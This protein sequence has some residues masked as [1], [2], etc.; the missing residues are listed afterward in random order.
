MNLKFEEMKYERPD[1]EDIRKRI[2]DF[3]DEF[4]SADN[5]QKQIDIIYD[6]AQLNREFD[7]NLNLV[8]VRHSIDTR[9]EFYD[10]EN[11]YWDEN[12]PLVL[13]TSNLMYKAI[14]NSKFKDELIEEFG[15]HYFDLM[16]CDLVLDERATPYLQK[17]NALSS[18]YSK[19][20]ANSKIEFRGKTYTL[21]Q[22]APHLQNTDRAYRKEAYEKRWGF[23]EDNQKKIDQ[24]YDDMVKERTAMAKALGFNSY[25]EL[26]YKL[27]KRTDYKASDVAEYREKVRKFVSPLAKKLR[28]EQSSRIGID[29]FKFYDESLEYTDGNPNPLGEEKFI[30]ENGQKMYRNLSKETGEFFDF[31]VEN[32]LLDLTAKP[33]KQGGGY[34]T[35]FD[36][37]K[38]PFIFANFNGT[39]GDIEVITHEAGHAFQNYMSQHHKL[40]EYVWPTMESAEIHSM[41]M[42]FLTWKYMELFVGKNMAEKY[43][44]SH[45]KNAIIFIP[46]GVLIDHFQ[47]V[48]YDNPELS[49]DERRAEF[50]KLEKMYR[51]EVD[52]DNEF[53]DKGSYWYTQGHVFGSP[54]YYI[55]YTLAQVCAFQFLLKNLEDSKEALRDYFELCKAGGSESF[56]KLVEIANIKNP[57]TTNIIEDIMPKLQVILEN[58]EIK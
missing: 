39:K 6:F 37:Y 54:F 17:I 46:Y 5:A 14:F 8:S 28:E 16:E 24:I 2:I 43:R 36:V 4:E 12:S 42:E 50:R 9:D 38:S 49:P 34:C 55:D 47:H 13:E 45:L 33:G 30:V 20:I 1:V 18:E 32:N 10:K 44:Y 22:M 52:F 23:F 53:L 51:P 26:A 3:K 41:S 31:M 11:E 35:S 58:L 40:P 15:Q 29:N 7:T 21:T 27:M 57:I 19:L 48:V 25:T 56:Y